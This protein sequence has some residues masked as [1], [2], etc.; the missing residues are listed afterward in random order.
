[1]HRTTHLRTGGA[2]VV[3]LEQGYNVRSTSPQI[4]FYG[5][6]DKNLRRKKA[7][8]QYM[9]NHR[10][11]ILSPVLCVSCTES[12]RN[13][14]RLREKLMS[15]ADHRDI[16]PNLHRVL[17]KSWQMLEELHF[18]PQELWLSWW[19]SARLGLQ[20]GLTEDRLQSALASNW[21]D[22][23]M[24][25]RL[26]NNCSLYA[27]LN[28]K[29]MIPSSPTVVHPGPAVADVEN[30]HQDEAEQAHWARDHRRQRH[31][32]QRHGLHCRHC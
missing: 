28:F 5:V 20:A 25:L 15:V 9:L 21:R 22:S 2:N 14:Q 17:P 13:I 19:D 18:K 16:F 6:T 7:Q 4:L 31:R 23:A 11:Q 32:S 24:D 1:M 3:A 29:K 27:R 8:L 26:T 30:Q 12:Q 10:L